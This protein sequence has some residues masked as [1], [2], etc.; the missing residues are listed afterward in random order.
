[1]A[2]DGRSRE[3]ACVA[4][5]GRLA[6]TDRRVPQRRRPAPTRTVERASDNSPERTGSRRLARAAVP[7]LPRGA[8]SPCGSLSLWERSARGHSSAPCGGSTAVTG[9]IGR[10]VLAGAL[11]AKGRSDPRA[12]RCPAFLRPRAWGRRVRLAPASA[13]IQRAGLVRRSLSGCTPDPLE[14]GRG[15]WWI[16][17]RTRSALRLAARRAESQS[18]RPHGCGG[19]VSESSATPAPE[20]QHVWQAAADNVERPSETSERGGVRHRREWAHH[21][22]DFHEVRANGPNSLEV[23]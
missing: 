22:L 19:S 11:V 17:L 9:S 23:M 1:V 14:R 10:P 16:G 20:A 3:P 13:T 5:H 2:G 4:P 15:R 12:R 8:V 18:A 7:V 21:V 6:Q